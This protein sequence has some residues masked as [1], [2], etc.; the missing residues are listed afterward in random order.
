MHVV[1][2]HD[3]RFLGR[4][5]P[6][7]SER[8]AGDADAIRRPFAR[9]T[10]KRHLQRQTLRLGQQR[11]RLVRHAFEEIAEGEKR[12]GAL[13]FRGSA[14]E[15]AVGATASRVDRCPPDGGLADP[16]FAFDHESRRPLGEAVEEA[17]HL[18]HLR[19]PSDQLHRP[20]PRRLALLE[21]RA[22]CEER[23]R[24]LTASFERRLHKTSDPEAA[25]W[26]AD[27]RDATG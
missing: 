6:K 25:G 4:R 13:R 15:K 5:G 24:F 8:A 9:R 10:H 18:G 14:D 11:E 22:T 20:A 23:E 7:D 27:E 17:I 26:G 16:R 3:S 12:Q 21:C 19:L 1:N 2:R